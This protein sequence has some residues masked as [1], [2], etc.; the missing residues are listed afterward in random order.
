MLYISVG[1]NPTKDCISL[2]IEEYG[3][4]FIPKAGDLRQILNCRS[5]MIASEI[6]RILYWPKDYLV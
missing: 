2:P 6:L 1:K 3:T 4:I 5:I